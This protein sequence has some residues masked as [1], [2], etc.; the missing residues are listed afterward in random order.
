MF[1]H[2]VIVLPPAALMSTPALALIDS[3]ELLEKSI[4]ILRQK[5]VDFRNEKC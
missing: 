3:T 1:A 2:S 5:K 4:A